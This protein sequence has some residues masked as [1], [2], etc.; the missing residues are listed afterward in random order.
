MRIAH[1]AN[2]YA[3][4]SGGMRTT[5]HELGRG[6]RAAGH[7][8]AMVVPGAQ[9]AVEQTPFGT[10]FTVP[11][12]ALPG[13]PYSV[14]PT[15]APVRRVL[16]LWRPDRLEVSD[17]TTLGRLGAWAGA[18]GLPAVLFAHERVDHW[19]QQFT[20]VGPLRYRDR[21]S[22]FADRWNLRALR[23]YD[24]IVC[25]TQYAADQFE[26][27]V[28]RSVTRIPLGA[29]VEDFDPSRHSPELRRELADAADVL[30]VHAGRLSREKAPERS[31]EAVR[32]LT[33][34]GIRVRLV[35]AG[36]GPARARLQRRAS[37]LPVTFLGFVHDRQRLA[38]L[39]ATADVAL[40]PGPI[41]TF[42]LSAV[43][44][45]AAGT[46]VVAAEGSALR[47]IVLPDAGEVAAPTGAA[48]ADAIERILIRPEFERRSAAAARGAAY[49]WD[50][51]VAGLLE[52]HEKLSPDTRAA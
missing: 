29:R 35:V 49:S 38:A 42:C 5:M 52:L 4:H 9:A 1:V 51:T 43:E 18:R 46:P 3:P 17:R 25:T 48:F 7:E 45:L 20:T 11:G 8:F 16:E 44:A 39:L 31:I 23:D 12:V 28:P 34:R 30:L 14:I 27:L 15:E 47:E 50:T 36:D 21:R 2:Y 41:E 22:P 24:R 10:R 6:Y 32:E 19:I 26:R 13:T 40:N 33:A 37:G